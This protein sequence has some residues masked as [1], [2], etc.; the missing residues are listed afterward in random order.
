[1]KVNRRPGFTHASA[2]FRL[3]VFPRG[4]RLPLHLFYPI[5][6]APT[7]LVTI[8]IWEGK[9]SLRLRSDSDRH[10]EEIVPAWTSAVHI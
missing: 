8:T 5:G 2:P 9:G 1:M 6:F 10:R 3:Q 7:G 4:P